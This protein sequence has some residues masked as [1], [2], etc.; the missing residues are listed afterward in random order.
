[1]SPWRSPRPCRVSGCGQLVSGAP[2][3]CPTHRQAAER[4]RRGKSGN[5]YGTPQWR[6]FRAWYVA[7]HPLCVTC[8][9]LGSHVDHIVRLTP[10]NLDTALDPDA[11][12]TLCAPCHGRKTWGETLGPKGRGGAR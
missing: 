2:G 6:A 3:L 4:G 7:T 11:V 9:Q 12:Q 8:G 1:V 5:L 10:A